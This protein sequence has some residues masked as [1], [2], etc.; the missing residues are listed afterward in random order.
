MDTVSRRVDADLPTTST[1]PSTIPPIYENLLFTDT[2]EAPPQLDQASPPST[3]L[4]LST[5]RRRVSDPTPL[6]SRIPHLAYLKSL[7]GLEMVIRVMR[8][9]IF[10]Q[11]Q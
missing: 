8:T 4:P 2:S 11:T 3:T 10:F 9:L 5:F 7:D 1:I 6:V